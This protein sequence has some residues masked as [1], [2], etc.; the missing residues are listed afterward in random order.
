MPRGTGGIAG[1][2]GT[3]CV[4]QRAKRLDG[5]GSVRR[6]RAAQGGGHSA[7]G[8][9]GRVFAA[10]RAL[11]RA[12][13]LWDAI[14]R[15]RMRTRAAHRRGGGAAVFIFRRGQGDSPIHRGENSGTLRRGCAA[16]AGRGAGTA[17][18]DQGHLQR[19]RPQ[20]R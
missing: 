9:C 3:H 5:A 13:E 10:A 11:G 17:G 8:V 6:R 14:L 7:G 19:T 15:R 1:H 12:Q 4:P 20:D 2:G 16:G 18:G